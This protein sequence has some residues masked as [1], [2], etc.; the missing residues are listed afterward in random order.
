MKA[1]EPLVVVQP[2]MSYG[3]GHAHSNRCQYPKPKLVP[4]KY[5]S[6]KRADTQLGRFTYTVP[7][8][9][10]A[11]IPNPLGTVQLAL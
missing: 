1:N 9:V 8:Q 6:L 5:L 10:P 7:P 2:K 4:Q 11:M 3:V